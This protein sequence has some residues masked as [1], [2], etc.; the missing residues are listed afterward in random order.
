LRGEKLPGSSKAEGVAVRG[1]CLA[2]G[3]VSSACAV[4]ADAWRGSTLGREESDCE[5]PALHSRTPAAPAWVTWRL[6]PQRTLW[7]VA[8]GVRE[9]RWRAS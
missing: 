7:E 3:V 9:R 1:A 4:Q 5:I 2:L 8:H 6:S